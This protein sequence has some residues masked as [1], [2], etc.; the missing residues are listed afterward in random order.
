M[1]VPHYQNARQNHEL[2]TANKSFENVEKFKY[3]GTAITNQKCIHKEIK[4]RLNVTNAF[5][6]SLQSLL[7]SCLLS[8]ILKRLKYTKP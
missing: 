8:K 4:S 7:S 5:Y 1:A 3:L 6:H 2:L